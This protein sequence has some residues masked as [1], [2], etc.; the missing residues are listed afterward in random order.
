MGL[1]Q[2]LHYGV[3]MLAKNPGFTAVAVLTLALGI[4]ANTAMFSIIDTVLLRMLP[5]KDPERLVLLQYPDHQGGFNSFSYRA[6]ECLRDQ[7]SVL[8]G[9]FG[10]TMPER[11]AVSVDGEGELVRGQIVSGGYYSTLGV[12][13]ALGRTITT[14]DDKISEGPSVAV[15]SY[16]YW[17]RRF[18]L[19]PSV[20]GKR[21]AINGFPF[22]IIGVTPPEFFGLMYGY[23]PDITAPISMQAVLMGHRS[24]LDDL[25]NWFVETIGGQLKPGVGQEQARA[26]LDLVFQQA[27]GFKQQKGELKIQLVPGSKGFSLLRQRFATPLTILMAMVGLVL[28]IACT[29]VANL[30]TARGTARRKEIAMRLALGASRPRLVRQLL[31]ECV[32][33]GILSGAAGL[34]VAVWIGHLLLAL[35]S[36]GPFP[37][38]FDFHLDSRILGFTGG[39]SVLVGILFG[40]VPVARA[41]QVDLTADLKATSG[42]PGKSRAGIGLGKIL[43]VSQVAVSLLLLVGAGL[44]VRTLRN[45]KGLN[46]GFD[47]ERVLLFSVEPTL[48]GYQG[49]R[50]RNLY[51]ELLERVQSIPG[52]RAVSLSRFGELTP[53]GSATRIISVP[54]YVP[55]RNEVSEVHLN[56][57]GPNFFQAMGMTLVRGRDF[58][59]QDDDNAPKVAVIN[60]TAARRYFGDTDPIGRSITLSDAPGEVGLIGIVRDTKYQSLRENAVAMLFAPFLQFPPDRLPRMTYEVRTVVN[61]ATL[62]AGIRQ[63]IQAIDRNLP[64]FDVKTLTEQANES[65]MPERLVATLSTLFGLLALALACVGLYGIMAYSVARRTNEIGIRMALGAQ[66]ADVL[67]MVLKDALV[68]VGIGLAIGIPTALASSRVISSLLFGLSAHDPWTIAAASVVLLGVALFAGYLPARRATKVDPMVALHYE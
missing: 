65:L 3:R 29:N 6:F 13:A 37:I 45:L 16:A 8:S 46:P 58:A 28:L 55:R 56:L 2:D 40:L 33:L 51:K 22:T 42:S 21:I 47:T 48:V 34:L 12:K 53:G 10:T 60:E 7:N 43:I 49:D 67:W 57:V 54:G 59:L 20:V 32:L 26:N 9:I 41:T 17:K 5:V 1:L 36:S 27:L 50:L 68:M 18:N 24:L 63:Q 61:P 38:S 64:M 35:V 25:D 66:Q 62:T 19:A 11:L 23:S 44:F 30:L 31:T 52:V 14:E 4:G 39:V 15:I